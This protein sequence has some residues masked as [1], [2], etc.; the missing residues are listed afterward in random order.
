M[1]K[2]GGDNGA[3]GAVPHLDRAIERARNNGGGR[4]LEGVD[5]GV[6][7]LDGDE[8]RRGGQLRVPDPER[9]VEGGGDDGLGVGVDAGDRVKVGGEALF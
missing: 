7:G 6:V 9:P 2:E 3:G 5:V 8:G 1:T 4:D